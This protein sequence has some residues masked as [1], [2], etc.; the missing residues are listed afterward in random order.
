MKRREANKLQDKPAFEQLEQRL[1][2]SGT[3][4]SIELFNISPALFVQNQGQ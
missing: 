3:D 4:T 2:L 1:M